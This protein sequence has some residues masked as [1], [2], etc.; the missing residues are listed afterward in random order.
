MRPD[1]AA[2]PVRWHARG[3]NNR[4]IFGATYQGVTHLPVPVSYGLGYVGTWLAYHLMHD[5]THRLVENFRVVRP[6]A[7]ERELHQLA[8]KTYRTYGRDVI[9]F[10]RGLDMDRA[11][12]AK[13]VY[14]FDDTRFGGVLAEGRGVI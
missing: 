8:L 7:S 13:R 12:L 1:V 4:L 9:D 14:E 5:R 2:A 3:L 6:D 11:A 10:I